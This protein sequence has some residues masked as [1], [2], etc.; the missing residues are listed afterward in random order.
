MVKGHKDCL[1]AWSRLKRRDMHKRYPPDN[2]VE[3]ARKLFRSLLQL[4][5]KRVGH[6]AS[7]VCQEFPEWNIAAIIDDLVTSEIGNHKMPTQKA[8]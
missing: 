2:I 6:I 1:V 7:D 4:A 5:D 3:D 8:A